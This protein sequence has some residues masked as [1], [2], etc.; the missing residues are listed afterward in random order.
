MQTF[1]EWLEARTYRGAGND[2]ELRNILAGRSYTSPKRGEIHMVRGDSN[3]PLNYAKV[4][5]RRGY[6][7]GLDVPDEDLAPHPATKAIKGMCNYQ[8]DET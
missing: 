3:I 6:L 5:N 7:F 2:Q 8:R 1:K 4:T